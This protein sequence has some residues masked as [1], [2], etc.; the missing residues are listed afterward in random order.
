MRNSIGDQYKTVGLCGS[1]R[2]HL[3]IVNQVHGQFEKGGFTV[4]AP[5]MISKVINPGD[6]F[7]VFE[8]DDSSNPQ[9]IEGRYQDRLL[10][11]DLV[12]VCNPEGYIGGSVMMELGR[13]TGMAEVYFMEEPQ[14]PVVREMAQGS[15]VPVGELIRCMNMH[16][17][18]YSQ[19][20][21]PDADRSLKSNFLL[22]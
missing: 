11:S 2:K 9:K 8:S 5:D 12:Y 13:L 7:V 3:G 14:E 21:W 17:E 22:G 19:R 1:F 16:N 15:V 20:E 18:L 6:E 4:L 10:K